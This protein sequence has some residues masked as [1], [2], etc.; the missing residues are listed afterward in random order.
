M[1]LIQAQK[2]H[3]TCIERRTGCM[4]KVCSAPHARLGSKGTIHGPNQK[5]QV[6][7]NAYDP[8]NLDFRTHSFSD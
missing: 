2:R 5:S 1:P 4:H 7:I 8:D 6:K 3:T